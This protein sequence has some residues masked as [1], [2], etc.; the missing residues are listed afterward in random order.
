[1]YEEVLPKSN[2]H[3]RLMID[4]LHAG[5]LFREK[6]EKFVRP[7]IIKGVPSLINDLKKTVYQDKGKSDILGEILNSMCTSMEKD[8]CL[9]SKDEEEQDPTVQLWLYYYCSQHQYRIG[10]IDESLTL[11]NKAIEHTPTVIE[12][13][14][15]K[16]KIMQFAGNRK[17]ASDLVD[18]SRDL[19]QADRYLNALASKYLFKID[20][21]EQAYKT[22]GMF[23]KEDANGNLNVHEMQ[24]MWF[25]NHCG[26]AHLRQGNLRQA[27]H[28]FW[29]IQRHLETMGDDIYDFHY[30]SYRKVTC[31][32]YL[33][34]LELQDEMYIG[35]YPVVGCLNIL[36]VLNKIAKS[37]ESLDD[38]LAKQ[39]EYKKGDD[40]KK[41]L[42][43]N[44]GVDEEDMPLTDPEGW[45]LYVKATKKPYEY[46]IKFATSV[47]LAN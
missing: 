33:Q 20:A 39:E 40:Y 21:I 16:A 37:G 47:A 15:H 28:Q 36:R 27:L 1:M 12:L 34:M 42:K 23:S 2:T 8:M 41:F 24:T 5:P 35:K 32:H 19:D 44:E 13:Y 45:D 11:I 31:N 14:I 22:M 4:I 30:Y 18:M 7:L 38:I 26:M 10:N 6:L 29:H 9:D 3:L 46:M 25:E 17:Q 43:D